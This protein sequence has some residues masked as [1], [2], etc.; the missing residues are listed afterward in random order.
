MAVKGSYDSCASW[1]RRCL[2]EAASQSP[3][4][5]L[6]STVRFVG[7]R[8]VVSGPRW[9]ILCGEAGV[10]VGKWRRETNNPLREGRLRVE[11]C[12]SG[13]EVGEAGERVL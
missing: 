5:L 9:K 3:G 13:S 10:C 12:R 7:Q 6:V 8:G 1:R 2:R 11:T 4:Q